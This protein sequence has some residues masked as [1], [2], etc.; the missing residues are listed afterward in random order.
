MPQHFVSKCRILRWYRSSKTANGAD[1]GERNAIESQSDRVLFADNDTILVFDVEN[2]LWS[3]KIERAA[4]NFGKIADVAFGY[5]SDDVLVFSNFGVR[6]TIWSLLS[7]RGV[8][9]KDPKYTVQCY[10][11]RPRTGHLAILTRP[12]AQDIL[13]LLDPGN[14]QLTRTVELGTTDA[15]EVSW[16]TDGCWLAIRDTPSAGH[17]VLI[18]TAD[19]HLFRTYTG[20]AD[21]NEIGLGI[22]CM[23]WI[24]SNG[25]LALGD[26]NDNVT[27][28]S[29]NTVTILL[30][31]CRYCTLTTT[32][33]LL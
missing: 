23:Q 2:S 6:L 13:L 11:Y 4:S 3:A 5:S 14:H 17:K 21:A 25:T 16:S 29:K 31:A 22:N 33:S 12:S 28:L 10:S 32:S 26:C 1:G 18:Y 8:V 15:Q 30:V 24:P 27:I 19:G 20:N 7:C 9:I